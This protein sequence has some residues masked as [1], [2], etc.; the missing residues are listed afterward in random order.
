MPVL[1]GDEV[2]IRP[3]RAAALQLL[4]VCNSDTTSAR[5]VVGILRTD[6]GMSMEILKVAN[7]PLY[8]YGG[9]IRSVEHATVILGF[10]EVSKLS[11]MLAS[12]EVF[13]KQDAASELR[14]SLWFHSLGCAC[15]ARAIALESKLVDSEAAFLAAIVHDIGKLAFLSV[16]DEEYLVRFERYDG[17]ETLEIEAEKF[18]VTHSDMGFLCTEDWG[19][20]MDV[21]DGI[22]LHHE[23]DAVSAGG[24]VRVV[25]MANAF[26]R[27]WH[28]G[29]IE[30]ADEHVEGRCAAFRDDMTEE[31]VERVE[32]A[33]RTEYESMITACSA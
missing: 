13:R 27:K 22:Q 32:Q 18:Q 11:L 33:A 14:Q 2:T 24:L 30:R 26:A 5:D 10:R 15:V 17:A 19:L 31:Q 23:D 20:P 9:R 7:S 29:S 6:A 16:C 28:I 25:A 4:D 21:V 8:G 12:A 1:L 3:L